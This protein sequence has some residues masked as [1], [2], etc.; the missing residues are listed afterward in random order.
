MHDSRGGVESQ[1]G[2]LGY[3]YVWMYS[4]RN[5]CLLPHTLVYIYLV[6]T[7][8]FASQIAIELYKRRI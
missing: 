2:F 3:L 1:V 6:P 4:F 8:P 7:L 5:V